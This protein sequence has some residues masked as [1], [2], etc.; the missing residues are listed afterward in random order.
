M[1]FLIDGH[2][3]DGPTATTGSSGQSVIHSGS[4]R[5]RITRDGSSG[6]PAEPGRY[7]LYICHACPFSHRVTVVWALRGLAQTINLSILHPRWD[8]ADGWVFGET[9]MST[10]DHGG[11]S[12]TCLR[13]AYL[14]S[15]PN[16]TGRVS[17]PVLWDKVKHTI[18]NNESLDIAL[19]LN[20]ELALRGAA[21]QPDL[22]PDPLRASIDALN[23]RTSQLLAAGVYN[24]A[25]ARNQTE[26]DLAT[27]QLFSFLDE[28]EQRL[29]QG[30]PFLFGQAITLAD[31]LVFTP[32]VR[33]DAVYA[34][35]FRV[36]RKRLADF[37]A[38]TAFVRRLYDVPEIAAT[39]H[40]DQILAHYYDSDWA[41]PPHRGIVPNLP[42]MAW[43]RRPANESPEWV[44]VAGQERSTMNA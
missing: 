14:A 28:L 7:H 22:Y 13:E 25:S 44:G 30:R 36:G 39:V 38:L 29:S 43:Y 17:V 12:F 33:F 19:M 8:A 26:Y 42:E 16:Y 2:W 10:N 1:K 20:G 4:F 24:I 35:L 40:F 37:P 23:A 15:R 3:T 27:R 18:V 21:P 34:P 9:A 5:D 32:L 31:V 6:F 11:S 41:I